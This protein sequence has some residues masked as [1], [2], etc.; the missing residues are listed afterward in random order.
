MQY[1]APIACAFK[2]GLTISKQPTKSTLSVQGERLTRL[3]LL[4]DQHGTK[5]GETGG[6]R[7]GL[8]GRIGGDK[9]VP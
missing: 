1:N 2:G 4:T 6:G 7:T 5:P 3:Q 9:A 8:R